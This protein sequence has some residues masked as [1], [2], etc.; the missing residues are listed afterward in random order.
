MYFAESLQPTSYDEESFL[1]E[2]KGVDIDDH[3]Q[4]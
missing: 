3:Y 4:N 2:E 1:D